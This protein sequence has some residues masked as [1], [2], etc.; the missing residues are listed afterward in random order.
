MAFPKDVVGLVCDAF[1]QRSEKL[2]AAPKPAFSKIRYGVLTLQL[3]VEKNEDAVHHI[4]LA[5][6]EQRSMFLK[7]AF[8]FMLNSK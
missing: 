3:L 5:V 4:S 7:A 6:A 8:K 1:L 2:L